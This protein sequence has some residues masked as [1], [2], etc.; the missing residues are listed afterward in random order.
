MCSSCTG[1]LNNIARCPRPTK[2]QEGISCQDTPA[3]TWQLNFWVHHKPNVRNMSSL[4]EGQMCGLYSVF[5]QNYVYRV[6]GLQ[7]ISYW[8]QCLSTW[9]EPSVM[10]WSAWSGLGMRQCLSQVISANV[11]MRLFSDPPDNFIF[12]NLCMVSG[13]LSNWDG[14]L[15]GEQN[16]KHSWYFRRYKMKSDRD[17]AG[18]KPR[19]ALDSLQKMLPRTWGD[20]TPQ[21]LILTCKY[22][23]SIAPALLLRRTFLY[24]QLILQD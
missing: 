24:F 19:S 20:A 4:E 7:N 16:P 3:D 2:P 10:S 5:F 6:N 22:S 14:K 12:S 9:S 13:V 11:D 15:S 21:A 17:E 23:N 1:L 8:A 18:G